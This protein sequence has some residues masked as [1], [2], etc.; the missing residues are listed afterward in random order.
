MPAHQT[1]PPPLNPMPS[2]DLAAVA[3]QVVG[4]ARGRER[5][6]LFRAKHETSLDLLVLRVN[7]R[8]V[9]CYLTVSFFQDV[10]FLIIPK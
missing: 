2:A 9:L 10:D 4:R 3:L 6:G 5:V 8:H 7:Y 1:V